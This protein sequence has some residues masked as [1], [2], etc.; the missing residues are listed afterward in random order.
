[1]ASV[2]AEQP[3]TLTT[4]V[5]A[6]ELTADT[7]DDGDSAIS[8][9]T[10]DRLTSLR[11]SVLKFQEENGRT[12]HSMSGGKYAFPNDDRENERLDLQHNLWLLTLR[13][14][15]GLSPKATGGAKRVLDAGTG[16]LGD[17]VRRPVPGIPGHRG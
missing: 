15:L 3:E 5:P 6:E 17:R 10:T 2:P 8:N 16:H 12:Y 9:P 4:T 13:G 11:S 7:F 14:D 1:M